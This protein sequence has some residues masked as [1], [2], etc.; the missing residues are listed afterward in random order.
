MKSCYLYL[1]FFLF[2]LSCKGKEEKYKYF[3]FEPQSIGEV[4]KLGLY[5]YDYTNISEDR[6]NVFFSNVKPDY[7]MK[8]RKKP[9]GRMVDTKYME[10]HSEVLEYFDKKLN[11][12]FV[13]YQFRNDSLISKLYVID[14]SSKAKEYDKINSVNKAKKLM[15]SLNIKYNDINGKNN[16]NLLM[17]KFNYQPVGMKGQQVFLLDN[18][19]PMLV[20]ANESLFYIE[21]FY[22]KANNDLTNNWDLERL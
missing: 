16:Q 15:D 12:N 11:N 4:R 5:K 20:N 7:I 14:N 9:L 18:K 13:Y 3:K 10:K 21:V 6:K 22:N 17:T 2:I 8:S 1:F 19:Y